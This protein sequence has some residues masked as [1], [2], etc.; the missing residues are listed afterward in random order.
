MVR[1]PPA[2]ASTP[3]QPMGQRQEQQHTRQPAT[4]LLPYK[5]AAPQQPQQQ[6]EQLQ[7]ASEAQ[8]AGLA[9]ELKIKHAFE[10]RADRH[11]R[12][13]AHQLRQLLRGFRLEASPEQLQGYV[14]AIATQEAWLT[15]PET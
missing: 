5:A 1:R 4:V 8:L 9:S 12:I 2:P 14:S 10:V 15:L 7:P 13:T 11:G 6:Q 3:V